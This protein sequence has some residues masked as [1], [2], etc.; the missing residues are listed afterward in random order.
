MPAPPALTSADYARNVLQTECQGAGNA[1]P[2]AIRG[3]CGAAGF[4]P[5]S[6]AQ[7]RSALFWNDPGTTEQPPGHWLDITDSVAA[8]QSLSTLQAARLTALL[9]QVETDAGVAVWGVKYQ[10]NLWRPITAIQDCASWSPNFT[11]CDPTWF[12][13]IAT[14]PHPDY[15]AG[16]PAFSGAAA[17][18][19]QA[20]LGDVPFTSTSDAYCNA[21]RASTVRSLTTNLIVAC[22]VP[23]THVFRV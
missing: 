17:T 7:A 1:L 12:S 14:P 23:G 8:S 6:T 21:N 13:L 9:G 19:L 20:A 18:L 2:A 3:V 10:Y 22:T 4:A 15:L 16:H 11:T 5:A